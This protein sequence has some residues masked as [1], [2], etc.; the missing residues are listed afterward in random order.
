MC[1]CFSAHLKP[2]QNPK[3]FSYIKK[4]KKIN[5]RNC[6]TSKAHIGYTIGLFLFQHGTCPQNHTQGAKSEEICRDYHLDVAFIL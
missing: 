1:I 4:K 5:S 3:D 2:T 6:K